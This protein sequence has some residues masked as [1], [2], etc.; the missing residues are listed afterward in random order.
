MALAG[1]AVVI[2]ISADDSSY[3]TI[4]GVN[5]SDFGPANDLL[6]TTD[7][8]DTSGARIRIQG[9][10]DVD[11]AMSGH[12]TGATAQAALYTA[13]AAGSVIYVKWAPN[14]TTG[15]K[16]AFKVENIKL[17]ASFDGTVQVAYSLKGTGVVSTF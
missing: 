16:A 4:D 7:F 12:Y 8:A 9:L 5:S 13:Y 17:S 1:H 6:E 15:F 2:G 11:C 10:K 14:G 3:T